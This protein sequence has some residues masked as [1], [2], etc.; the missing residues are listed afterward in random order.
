M[1]SKRLSIEVLKT[2]V[3][4]VFIATI[5]LCIL[6]TVW[7]P[8][9]GK[10]ENIYNISRN[11]AYIGIMALGQT[12]VI[13]AGGID[14]SVGSVMGLAG[15]V[16]GVL[17]ESGNS[18]LVSICGGLLAAL[19]CGF[20][21]GYL[22][23]YLRLSPFVVTLGTLSIARSLA[24]VYSNNRMI[25]EFGPDQE[26][27]LAIGSAQVF[28][29]ASPV[30]AVFVCLLF[31]ALGLNYGVLG[32]HLY[33]IGGNEEAARLNGVAVRRLKLCSYLFSSLSA[34]VAAVLSVAWL[35]SVTSSMGSGYELT[36][37]A[38]CVI[39]GVQLSGGEGG[40]LGALLGAF[41]MEVIRNGL[42][43]AGVDPYWQGCFVGAF[44]VA[45]V[46]LGKIR[47]GER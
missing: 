4:W 16:T 22:I 17:L 40:P 26:A 29:L 23:A 47:S 45:A 31:A 6:L 24:L 33:A 8:A 34:G 7:A 39:G 42:L 21:N 14:L 35:G 41:L 25:Y 27:F 19:A 12:L 9:F 28:G 2:Q 5:L 36:V 43:L 37:I 30:I 18:A 15:V 10:D 3:F 1:S 11:A 44:I 38:A 13:I 46:A 32:R 20:F